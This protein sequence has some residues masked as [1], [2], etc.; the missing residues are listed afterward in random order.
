MYL[1]IFAM[2]WMFVSPQTQYVEILMPNVIVLGD[3]AFERCL[4]HEN[5]AFNNGISVLVRDPTEIPYPFHYVRTW[6]EATGYE[7]GRGSSPEP[8]YTDT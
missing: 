1:F 2:V 7:S 8:D 4:G 5:G 3:G 6:Q